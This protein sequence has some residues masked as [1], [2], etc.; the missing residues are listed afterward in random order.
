[1]P[2]P[3]VWGPPIWNL[4][5]VFTVNLKEQH[6]KEIGLQLFHYFKRLS[7]FLPC[8]DCSRHSQ[9]FFN[10]IKLSDIKS[11]DSL[12]NIYYICHNKV[13]QRNR[14]KPFLVG[15]L[16]QYQYADL[17]STFN[18]FSKNYIVKGDISALSDIFHRNLIFNSFK[19]WIMQHINKFYNIHER[20]RRIEFIQIEKIIIK[21]E[22]EEQ[23]SE[24]SKTET[25]ILYKEDEQEEQEKEEDHLQI[26][27]SIYDPDVPC[28][29]DVN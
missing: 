13:N 2:K 12:V 27:E 6:F 8:P 29:I 20:P 19:S 22:K 4:F 5:H 23:S 25:T 10:K 7:N 17:I 14:K 1:M 28:Y 21:K 15:D 3:E 18:N 24:Q 11:K 9:I 26:D 16:T